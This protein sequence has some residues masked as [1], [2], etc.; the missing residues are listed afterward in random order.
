MNKEK[1]ADK[2]IVIVFL[3]II[4][5]FGVPTIVQASQNTIYVPDDHTT[6]QAA[7]NT[8]SADDT[9]YVRAG[10]YN[11][12][13]YVNK[14]LKLIGE[15]M[16]V[17]TVQ[18]ADPSDYVFCVTSDW[19]T[20]TGFTATVNKTERIHLT[21]AAEKMSSRTFLTKTEKIRQIAKASIYISGASHC[22]IS[23]NIASGDFYG[24]L[25]HMSNNN[26]I[27][28]NIVSGNSLKGII[29]NRC[30]N[31]LIV[32]NN[33]SNNNGAGIYLYKSCFNNIIGN[34]ANN[35]NGSGI[36]LATP[37]QWYECSTH[38]NIRRNTVSYNNGSDIYLGYLNGLN[39]II[40]NNISDIFIDSVGNLIHHNNFDNVYDERTNTWDDGSKGNYY[41]YYEGTDMDRDG[42]GDMPYRPYPIAGTGRSS[43]DRYPLMNPVDITNCV[44]ATN[45]P[46]L[47]YAGD[48]QVVAN[49]TMVILNGSFST[50]DT[51]I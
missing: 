31:N 41:S 39:T 14:Q 1:V 40:Y 34:T 10:T 27:F 38:N 44:Y 17:V 24:I 15:G 4:S 30:N 51:G 21:E 35:N 42:I 16:D 26:N 18:A 2:T 37:A 19:V 11:E 50:D 32:G 3:L 23:Y 28:G 36:H 6:I 45:Q 5:M 13:V 22:N 20:I 12:N 48:D 46:P 8:A 25:L 43:M 33:A 47:A 7:V 29:L 9:I 49:G